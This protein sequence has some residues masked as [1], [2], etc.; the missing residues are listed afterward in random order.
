MSTRNPPTTRLE[1][2]EELLLVLR[3]QEHDQAAKQTLLDRNAGLLRKLVFKLMHPVELPLEDGQQE[4]AIGFL[5]AVALF[6]QTKGVRLGTYATPHILTRLQ[7]ARQW[8]KSLIYTPTHRHEDLEKFRKL[9][10]KLERQMG[11]Q[12]TVEEASDL[13][14]IPEPIVRDLMTHPERP[15]SFSEQVS[16]YGQRGEHVLLGDLIPDPSGDPEA[17]W[18]A[19]EE[20]EE[21]LSHIR[22]DRDRDIFRRHYG[23]PP[24]VD[25]QSFA[26]IAQAV[27]GI[28]PQGVHMVVD[29]ARTRLR[30]MF[31]TDP[32]TPPDELRE[33]RNA[34]LLKLREDG[35]ALGELATLH[36]LS[37][38]RVAVLIKEERERC[39]VS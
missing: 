36:N 26:E 8:G 24:Y 25:Q 27:G 7:R 15:R 18:M 9:L 34:E 14:Y 39:K 16:G 1:A 10:L 12:P 22:K 31:G 21:V 2:E 6:D 17:L 38:R 29:R 20:C 23:L 19:K 5:R 11:R 30:Q 13:L 33:T 37:K 32:V 35:W 4:A 3:A 28:T